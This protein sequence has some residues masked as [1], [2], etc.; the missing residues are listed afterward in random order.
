MLLA[1]S[2]NQRASERWGV[3]VIYFNNF[4]YNK[5][6]EQRRVD[7][8]VRTGPKS[9]L[10]LSRMV[11]VSQSALGVG[12]GSGPLGAATRS[13]RRRRP[14]HFFRDSAWFLTQTRVLGFTTT[15]GRRTKLG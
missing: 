10:T 5:A 9:V 8:V 13:P 6:V 14:F 3:S 11:L 12:W 4:Q 1:V 15:D 2:A 7:P